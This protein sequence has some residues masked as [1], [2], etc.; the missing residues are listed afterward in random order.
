MSQ[1]SS[2][3]NTPR[4]SKRTRLETPDTLRITVSEFFTPSTPLT[5]RNQPKNTENTTNVAPNTIFDNPPSPSPIFRVPVL[6]PGMVISPDRSPTQ[7]QLPLQPEVQS[8]IVPIPYLPLWYER[9]EIA[10]I[11]Y[12]KEKEKWLTVHPH[13]E[14]KDYQKARGF[15]KLKNLG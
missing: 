7:S 6:P 4:P 13:I 1:A 3:S 11:E 2:I 12:Q 15:E 9:P 8:D 14:S 10:M 5:L